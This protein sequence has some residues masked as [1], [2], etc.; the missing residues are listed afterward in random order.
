MAR[1]AVSLELHLVHPRVS[2]N[3]CC[4]T[5]EERDETRRPAKQNLGCAHRQTER[6]VYEGEG[7]RL[8]EVPIM[9][10]RRTRRKER[11]RPA[12]GAFRP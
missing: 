5:N 3:L 4:S 1:S 12:R 9:W 6:E 8:L 7:E 11:E 2:T 10:E